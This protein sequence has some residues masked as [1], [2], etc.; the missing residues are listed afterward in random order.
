[1]IDPDHLDQ[2]KQELQNCVVADRR[3]LDELRREIRPLA[4]ATRRIQP[5]A[6]TAISIVGTDGGNNRIEY[7]PFMIQMIRVVDSSEN[8]H[9]LEVV[10]PSTDIARLDQRHAPGSGSGS[11]PLGRMMAYLGVGHLWE[12]TPM[13]PTP[14]KQPPSSWVQVFRE[15]TEWAVLFSLLR[16]REFGT[17]TIIVQDGFLRSKVFSGTLF[18]RLCE[19]INEAIEHHRR[20]HRRHLHVVGVA[21]HSK[22][23]QRYRLAM[24]LEGIMRQE[25]P[26]YVEIPR[27]IEAKA[28]QWSEYARGDDRIGEGGEA[29]KFVGGK[30]FFVKFGS[31]PHDPIWPVD[32]LTSQAADAPRTLGSLLADA[33][34]GFP[35]PF[36]PACLQKAHAHAALVGFDMEIL[37]QEV[38]DTI[39]EALGDRGPVLDELALLE[40]DPSQ[41]RYR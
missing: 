4:G 10:T 25:Y 34:E 11:T 36:Y 1:M 15:L 39:R 18:S 24:A 26:C 16:E 17:D 2:L 6:T 23:I 40:A 5:R 32:L 14:P 29:N 27:D 38:V 20:Q 21:K 31:R 3:V 22:V 13:I 28:Y 8:Q 33:V 19:G 30:M 7:D 12:L 41:Q 37:Q 9:W 35:V